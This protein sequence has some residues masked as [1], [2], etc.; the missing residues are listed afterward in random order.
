MDVLLLSFF[1]VLFTLFAF[2]LGQRYFLG[3]CTSMARLDG[4]TEASTSS[5]AQ[6]EKFASALW[7]ESLRLI[8]LK[9]EEMELML[10]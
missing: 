4:K 9:P 5:A 10:L 7:E 3:W 6:D 8:K 2:K 1:V